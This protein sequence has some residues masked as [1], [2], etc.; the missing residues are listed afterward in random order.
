MALRSTNNDSRGMDRD[1]AA[2]TASEAKLRGMRHAGPAKSPAMSEILYGSDKH[3][4]HFQQHR[5]GFS[6]TSSPQIPDSGRGFYSG[7]DSSQAGAS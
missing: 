2:A 6:S 7:D 5:S 3:G 1:F 4:H